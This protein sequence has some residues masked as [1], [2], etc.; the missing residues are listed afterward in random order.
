MPRYGVNCYDAGVWDGQ[1]PREVEADSAQAAAESVCGEP[2]VENPAK[3]GL[4]RAKVWEVK[5]KEP[6]IKW[7][8]RATEG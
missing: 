3:L 7:F 8:R 6:D 1:K 5:A 4:I 2:L